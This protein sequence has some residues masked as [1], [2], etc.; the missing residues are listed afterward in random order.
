MMIL[1]YKTKRK[2]LL[3]QKYECICVFNNLPL[4]SIIISYALICQ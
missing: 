2:L 1:E 3:D 4:I